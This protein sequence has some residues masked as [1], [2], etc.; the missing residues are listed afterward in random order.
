ML[1][2]TCFGSFDQIAVQ[3]S[4]FKVESVGDC[5]VAAA[6]LPTATDKHAHIMAEFALAIQAKFKS[7]VG[8]LEV[9]LGPDTGDLSLRVGLH[10]GPGKF[11]LPGPPFLWNILIF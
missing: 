4:V 9:L 5:Y 2:E 11:W 1:L 7:L 6:G 8:K 10:S 3:L